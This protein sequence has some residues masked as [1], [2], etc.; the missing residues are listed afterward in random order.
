MD[1]GPSQMDTFDLKPGT[2]NGGPFKEIQTAAE[3]IRFS[4]HLP[5]IAKFADRMAV[6]RSMTTKE[7]EHT[8]AAQLM[9]TGTLA[10]DQIDSPA[11][12]SLIAQ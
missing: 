7:G 5:K 2:A 8:R 6:V 9:H 11:L 1:G 4:E 10:M 12:G 3:P